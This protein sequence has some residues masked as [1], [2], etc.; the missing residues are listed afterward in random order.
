M[1]PCSPNPCRCGKAAA[2][3]AAAACVGQGHSAIAALQVFVVTPL[4]HD[5]SGLNCC[6][7]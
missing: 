7:L 2:A 6:Q 3:A 1:T 5:V 4:Q